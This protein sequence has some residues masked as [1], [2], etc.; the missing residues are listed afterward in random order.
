MISPDFNCLEKA[1][2][3]TQLQSACSAGKWLG[4]MAMVS[5]TPTEQVIEGKKCLTTMRGPPCFFTA[6]GG[7]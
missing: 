3:C 4:C 2:V 7:L 6:P 5:L 1:E